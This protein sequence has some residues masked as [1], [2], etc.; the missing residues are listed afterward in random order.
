MPRRD[1]SVR[2]EHSYVGGRHA[3][4][5]RGIIAA[6]LLAPAGSVVQAQVNQTFVPQGSAPRRKSGDAP[7][8]R[9][10]SGAIVCSTNSNWEGWRNER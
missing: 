1:L 3:I 8:D 7:P 4:S 5:A 10:V 9:T 2:L 6:A